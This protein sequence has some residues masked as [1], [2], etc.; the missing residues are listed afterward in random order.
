MSPLFPRFKPDLPPVF[1]L[2][3]APRTEDE[4]RSLS[5]SIEAQFSPV[6]ASNKKVHGLSGFVLLAMTGSAIAAACG[7]HHVVILALTLLPLYIYFQIRT[8]IADGDFS[9]AES[10]KD[11]I[12]KDLC[13]IECRT[14]AEEYLK[15]ASSE[16][17]H[18][19]VACLIIALADQGRLP[20][21]GEYAALKSAQ[22]SFKMKLQK[23]ANLDS[24]KKAAAQLK[25]DHACPDAE[26]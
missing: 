11:Q 16:Q 4:M 21:Y 18:P 22:T 25:L 12:D 3:D 19:D 7:V 17:I 13:I 6:Q 10:R 23:Q 14:K 2:G 9:R 1:K 8:K 15:V 5:Q 26:A 20:T 24:I